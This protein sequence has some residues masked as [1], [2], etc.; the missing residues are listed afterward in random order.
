MHDISITEC[1]QISGGVSQETAISGNLA[2]VGM[3]VAVAVT[4]ATAPVWFPVA[5]IAVS[6][7]LTGSYINDRLNKRNS[8]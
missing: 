3:G 7:G 6:V 8:H 1:H 4:G 5:M 2:V